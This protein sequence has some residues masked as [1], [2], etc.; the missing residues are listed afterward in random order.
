MRSF[1][2]LMAASHLLAAAPA[3]LLANETYFDRASEGWYWYQDPPEE[4]EPEPEPEPQ[5][6]PP[7]PQPV[8]VVEL[9]PIQPAPVPEAAPE[10]ASGPPPGSVEFL[11]QAMPAALDVATDNPTPE[12]VERYL[13]LQ[14]IALDRSEQFSEMVAMVSTGHPELDE[15]RRRPW[16]DTFAKQMEKAAEDSKREVLTELFKR[17]ALIMFV[18]KNCASCGLMGDNFY[19]MQETHGLVWQAISMDG[20]VLPPEMKIKQSF[21]AGLAANLG[22][23]NGG[24]VFLASPPNTYIPVTWNATGGAE[25]ADRILMV[26]RRAG[27][28][29][30]EDFS[31]TQAVNPRVSEAEPIQG[32]SMPDI[33]QRADDFLRN[34]A[35]HITARKE[36]DQ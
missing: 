24:A 19:R 14:K 16:Q 25:I 18:D 20:T 30:S 6:L 12:N 15:G 21:D 13:L 2:F 23:G 7:P 33:L 27:L 36:A 10:A 32:D 11:R 22:V 3:A 35:L 28:V 34:N 26:A 8:E 9:P 17:N 1:I 5:P 29:T 4:P 31:R